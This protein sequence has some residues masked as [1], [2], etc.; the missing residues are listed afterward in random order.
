MYDGFYD[1][2]MLAQKIK[3]AKHVNDAFTIYLAS[4]MLKENITVVFPDAQWSAKPG[5]DDG[6]VIGFINATH[7]RTG[8]VHPFSEG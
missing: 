5:K 3:E 7:Y 6:I 8:N 2:L 1:P 4:E